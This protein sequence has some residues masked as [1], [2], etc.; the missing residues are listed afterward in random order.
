MTSTNNQD[1][2]DQKD[3]DD[4][5]NDIAPNGRK[6]DWAGKKLS[7]ELL[8]RAYDSIDSTKADR[9]RECGKYLTF[10]LYDDN[11]KK[12]DSMYSCRVRLCPMCTWRRSLKVY[13]Q[14]MRILQEISKSFKYQYIM[15]TLTV[16]SCRGDELSRNIDNMMSAYNRLMGYAA[17][18][19]A[20]KGWYRSL[21]VTHDCTPYI[22]RDMYYGNA[23]KHIKSRRNYYNKMCLHIGDNNPSY[24]T[25]HPHYHV[26]IAVNPSYFTSRY[27][28]NHK[29]WCELWQCACR[30]DYIPQVDVRRVKGKTDKDLQKAVCEVAK[31]AAKDTDYIVLGNW[32]LTVSTVKMLDKALNGRRLVAYGGLLKDIK[33][34]LKLDDEETGDLVHID[35]DV[36][37]NEDNYR[38]I[39]YWWWTG[40][41]QYYLG[42]NQNK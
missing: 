34:L 30:L 40:Y 27:Y 42:D 15:L 37:D 35:G 5:L 22:T 11:T 33:S 20:C 13:G 26:L 39:T 36:D 41:R 4:E 9:L 6:R 23:D 3:Q 25:Y 2:K 7:N 28:I 24:D 38:L 1:K 31:Y 12:L 16:K 32:D 21:E 14:T 29:R 8:A 17:I 10:R 19:R 18:K